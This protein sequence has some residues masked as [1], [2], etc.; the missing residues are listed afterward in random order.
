MME[1]SI[2]TLIRERDTLK[3]SKSNESKKEQPSEPGAEKRRQGGK[4]KPIDQSW[5]GDNK[6]KGEKGT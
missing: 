1:A 5:K 4:F 2:E 6:R 3:T